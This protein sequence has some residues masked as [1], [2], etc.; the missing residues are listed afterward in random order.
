[1]I[2]PSFL[3][4]SEKDPAVMNANSLMLSIVFYLIF[5]FVLIFLKEKAIEICGYVLAAVLILFGGYELFTYISSPAI[6]KVTESRLA[7]A[8]ICLLAGGMLA[9][10]PRFLE[11][12][13]P[14]VW[15][16]FVLF[17]AFVKIQ[18]AFDQ[19]S[20]KISKWWIMLIFAAVSLA[21]GILALVNR[22]VK[23]DDQKYLFIGIM[24]IVEAVLDIVVFFLKNHAL[25]KLAVF[26]DSTLVPED[27]VAPVV[28]AVQ[29]EIA[30]EEEK[31]AEKE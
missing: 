22:N 13:L 19:L 28:P 4:R 11:W 6:R 18:Y 16:M 3:R 10:N 17:G 12:A 23:M 9:F 24:L 25:K 30:A 7:V 2:H 27:K 31:E 8:L 5:G 26:S 20:L 21:I 14:V 29:E 1:M 15:G